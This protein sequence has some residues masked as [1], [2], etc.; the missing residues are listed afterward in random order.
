MPDRYALI[1]NPVAH[2]ISP[3]I[4]A[5]FAQQTQQNLV[6]ELIRAPRGGFADAV[7]AFIEAGGKGMNVTLPFKGEACRFADER[8]VAAAVS[9]AANTLVFH[10][11]G[12]V[13][14]DNTDGA[15]LID[16]LRRLGCAIEGRSLL[17]V[18]AGGACRGIVPALLEARPRRLVIA[19][20]TPGKA[21]RIARLFAR[22]GPVTAQA[23]G[24]LAGRGFDGLVNATSASLDGVTPGLDESVA[25]GLQWGYD[26]AY[27]NQPTPFMK[28]LQERGVAKVHDGAGM[29]VAQAA[30]SFRLW[31]GVK[32]EVEK[33]L[34]ALPEM[35]RCLKQNR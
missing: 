26:L 6:Y 23:P 8:S 27:A 16:D 7:A 9:E 14:A 21:Q 30:R 35:G 28:W 12:T 3:R 25:E 5:L 2:S 31:R 24:E 22:L 18:G 10:D 1:G 32:P 4:H 33:V 15:G 17:V 13:H 11:D 19:N 20:R 34:A 29:L